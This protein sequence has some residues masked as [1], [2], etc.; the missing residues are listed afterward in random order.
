MDRQV[1]LPVGRVAPR[2]FFNIQVGDA[3]QLLG[4]EVG[5]GERVE[6]FLQDADFAM[7]MVDW[8]VFHVLCS[9]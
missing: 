2:P 9:D 8:Q 4:E 3:V 5:G 6:Q 7:T 1:Q